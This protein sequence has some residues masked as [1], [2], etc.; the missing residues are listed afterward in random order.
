[1]P[2]PTVVVSDRGPVRTIAVDRPARRNA[3]DHATVERLLAEV[4]AAPAA[5][6]RVVVVTGTGTVAFSSGHDLKEPE[7][8]GLTPEALVAHRSRLM[9]LFLAVDRSAIPVVARVNG[10]ALGAGLG[11]ALVAD[12]VVMADHAVLATPEIDVGRWPMAVGAVLLQVAPR[13]LA[14]EMMMTGRRVGA[15]EARAA[16]L[17]DRVV[18]SD[19]LDEVTAALADVLAAKPPRT[20]AV[21]REALRAMRGQG[22]GENLDLARSRL[23]DVIDSDEAVAGL[24][25][26]R[27]S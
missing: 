8:T 23:V 4:V 26:F 14:R 19:A 10:V 15:D 17:V 3:L 2:S 11:L 24:A 25:S 7:P 27:S 16:G 12:L 21:G 9:D 18:P 20:L 5:G 22:L 6:A 1:M 13:R